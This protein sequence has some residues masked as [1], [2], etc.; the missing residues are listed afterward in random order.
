MDEKFDAQ[1]AEL[2]LEQQKMKVTVEEARLLC[3]SS[4][5][6][7]PLEEDNMSQE[8]PPIPSQPVAAAQL[9]AKLI[10]MESTLMKAIAS[11]AGSASS[12]VSADRVEVVGPDPWTRFLGR[13]GC[14]KPRRAQTG[15]SCAAYPVPPARA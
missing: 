15:P 4:L 7:R 1:I 11:T 8:L 9:D 14:K 12:A 10:T 13:S 3:W 5:N 2:R 6:A